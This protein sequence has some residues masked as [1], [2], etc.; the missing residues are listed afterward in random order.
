MRRI[1]I[2][3]IIGVV[4]VIFLPAVV[5]YFFHDYLLNTEFL[6]PFVFSEF[7]YIYQYRG[8]VFMEGVKV[9]KSIEFNEITILFGNI[10]SLEKTARARFLGSS[11]VIEGDSYPYSQI[12]PDILKR[13]GAEDQSNSKNPNSFRWV[14]ERIEGMN[15]SYHIFWDFIGTNINVIGIY[16]LHPP[17]SAKGK[18][19]IVPFQFSIDGSELIQL[20]IKEQELIR[21]LGKPEKITKKPLFP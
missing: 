20:P 6:Q 14:I 1:L 12:T 2:F 16:F 9:R 7:K 15:P 19:Q 8:C 5:L 13:Y 3:I 18:I 21:I 10:A 11:M 4:I 17:D